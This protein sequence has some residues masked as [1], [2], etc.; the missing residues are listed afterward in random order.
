MY[1]KIV[2]RLLKFTQLSKI[3]DNIKFCLRGKSGPKKA[4]AGSDTSIHVGVKN[5]VVGDAANNPPSLP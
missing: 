2:G 5:W 3:I 4:R 1:V